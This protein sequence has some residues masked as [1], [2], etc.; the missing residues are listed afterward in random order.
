MKHAVTFTLYETCKTTN[1][2]SHRP[3]VPFYRAHT[4]LMQ[5]DVNAFKDSLFQSD[6]Y[7]R[8]VKDNWNF[9]KDDF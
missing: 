2:N 7:Q 4:E 5:E 9:F 1:N 8:P 6:P 3:Y